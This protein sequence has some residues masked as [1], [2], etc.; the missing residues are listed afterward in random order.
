MLRSS[1]LSPVIRALSRSF[2]FL[3]DLIWVWA[4]QSGL[5]AQVTL[6]NSIEPP[7]LKKEKFYLKTLEISVYSIKLVGLLLTVSG[8]LVVC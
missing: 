5:Q 4:R 1:L 6:L 3:M 8:S 2:D 7:F